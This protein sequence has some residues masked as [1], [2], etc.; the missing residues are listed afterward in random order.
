MVR[1]KGKRER[2]ERER[3]REREGEREM[4]REK[5]RDQ[6]NWGRV[7]EQLEYRIDKRISIKRAVSRCVYQ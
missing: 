3:E 2:G 6:N 7:K 4:E 1:K 5:E